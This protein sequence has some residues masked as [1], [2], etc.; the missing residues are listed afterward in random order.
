V[1]FEAQPAPARANEIISSV[2]L[3]NSPALPVRVVFVNVLGIPVDVQGTVELS[4]IDTTGAT[5]SGTT[6]KQTAFYRLRA[7]TRIVFIGIAS[8]AAIIAIIS[9]SALVVVAAAHGGWLALKLTAVALM[10][11]FHVYCGSLV[12]AFRL[13]P[14]KRNPTLLHALV[15]VPTVLVPVVFY[16][17]LAKPV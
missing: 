3:A 6:T 13:F 4:L 5:L 7:M 9:G 16:L 2:P 10:V 17:V 11:M 1:R 14:V 12:A 8:P 15:I